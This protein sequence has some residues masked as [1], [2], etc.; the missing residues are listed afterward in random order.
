MDSADHSGADKQKIKVPR[1]EDFQPWETCMTIT[2]TWAYRTKDRNFKN[3]DTLIREH[4][5]LSHFHGPCG[6]AAG[7]GRYGLV[8]SYGVECAVCVYG[9]PSTVSK[10]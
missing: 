3:V 4:T 6:F 7:C 2:E 1:P 5:L 10:W 9:Y 8:V